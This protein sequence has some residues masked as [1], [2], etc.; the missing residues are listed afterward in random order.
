[1]IGPSLAYTWSRFCSKEPV[2][3]NVLK[4]IRALVCYLGHKPSPSKRILLVHPNG[5]STLC[6]TALFELTPFTALRA[7]IRHFQSASR[8]FWCCR[9]PVYKTVNALWVKDSVGFLGLKAY[10]LV[11]CVPTLYFIRSFHYLFNKLLLT[12]VYL[13]NFIFQY[14]CSPWDERHKGTPLLNTEPFQL[15]IF[16]IKMCVHLR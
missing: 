13:V 6:Q 12:E 7:R 9:C 8:F 2:Y 15:S 3:K 10:E 11:R 14:L 1:M 5:L 4:L 16:L